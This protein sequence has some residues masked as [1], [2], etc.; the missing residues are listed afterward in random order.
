MDGGD[1]R[2]GLSGQILSDVG[3]RRPVYRSAL[4]FRLRLL[5]APGTVRRRRIRL[6]SDQARSTSNSWRLVMSKLMM[7]FVVCMSGALYDPTRVLH[8]V[9]PDAAAFCWTLKH[10]LG[11]R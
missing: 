5:F 1:N 4:T 10:S 3:D 6:R 8:Y 2:T 7:V 11:M 9:G